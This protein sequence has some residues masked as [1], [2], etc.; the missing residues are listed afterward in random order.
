MK[1]KPTK[2]QPAD[3]PE[4]TIVI[5]GPGP[6]S[7]KTVLQ[8]LLAEFL[9]K[10]GHKVKISD[11]AHRTVNGR[12]KVLSDIM[13]RRLFRDQVMPMPVAIHVNGVSIGSPEELTGNTQSIE[14][15]L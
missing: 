2:F 14:F 6:A 1:A 7:G 9:S 10:R 5:R 8:M 13:K 15:R 11:S 4:L 3:L 12:N